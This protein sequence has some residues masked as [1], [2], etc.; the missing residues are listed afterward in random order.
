MNKIKILPLRRKRKMNVGVG[1]T[2]VPLGYMLM[3]WITLKGPTEWFC[4]FQ[5]GHVDKREATEHGPSEDLPLVLTN[6][7]NIEQIKSVHGDRLKTISKA[8]LRQ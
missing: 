8:I 7:G 3:T 4:S 1:N 6:E 5:H 2:F